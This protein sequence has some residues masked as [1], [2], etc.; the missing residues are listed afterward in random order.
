[1][2]VIEPSF[3][4]LD[5]VSWSSIMRKIERCGRV[6]YKSE[7][8]ITA[9]S[10]VKFIHTIVDSGHHSVLEHAI[11]TIVATVN[12]GVS[13]EWVRHRIGSYSQ[14]S[15]RYCNYSKDKF[16]GEITVIKPCFFEEGSGLYSV[17][18]HGCKEAELNYFT[19]LGAGATPEEARDVLP[20]ATKTEIVVTFN[21]REWRHFLKLRTGKASHPQIREI[22]MKILVSFA[23][24]CP[25]LFGDILEEAKHE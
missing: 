16:G 14:E 11:I 7:D 23:E 4:Y 9:N 3:E 13:H 12:R 19:L 22:A 5:P 21:I 15:T 20:N 17:W 10:D 18:Y 25:A 2:R 24:E 6:C 1:M 8:R